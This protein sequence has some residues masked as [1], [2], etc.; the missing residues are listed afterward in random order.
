MS[1]K[2]IPKLCT[3]SA[4]RDAVGESDRLRGLCE[5]YCD[6]REGANGRADS[7]EDP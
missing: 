5:R 7:A 3:R 1:G 4:R 2:R 6:F